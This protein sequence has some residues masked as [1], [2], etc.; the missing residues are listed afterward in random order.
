MKPPKQPYK[1][2]ILAALPKAEI[3][4]VWRVIFHL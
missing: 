4:P 2:R 1:N 3:D